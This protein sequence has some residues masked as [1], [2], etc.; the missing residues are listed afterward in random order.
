MNKQIEEMAKIAF[1]IYNELREDLARTAIF[2]NETVCKPMER[3]AIQGY[4]KA[5]EVAREI[6]AEIEKLMTLLDKRH[7]QAGN[8]KQAWG[9]RNAM[10]E[11]A[12]LKKKYEV[13]EDV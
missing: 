8:P 1:P 2:A 7:M 11:I 12:E 13:T 9:I 10:W 5:S 3:L 6:F 4:R